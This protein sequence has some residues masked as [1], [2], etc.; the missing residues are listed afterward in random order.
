MLNVKN[1]GTHVYNMKKDK[2]KLETKKNKC[3]IN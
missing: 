2:S 3:N 1:G